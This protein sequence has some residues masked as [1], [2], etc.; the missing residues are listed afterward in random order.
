MTK[1]RK[2]KK[3]SRVT[4]YEGRVCP[5]NQVTAKSMYESAY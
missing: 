3:E 5:R 4:V 1:E 2:R